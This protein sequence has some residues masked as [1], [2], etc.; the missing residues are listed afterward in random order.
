MRF[1][2]V[3]SVLPTPFRSDASVDLDSLRRVIELYIGAG[4]DGVT[5]LGVT[6]EV[7]R[8]NERE[9][10]E[11]IESVLTEVSGRVPVVA[12]T[13]SQE[14]L[15]CIEYSRKAQLAGATAVM[16]SPPPMSALNSDAVFAHFA[17]L[18]SA[19][20]IE[21]VMQDY[22]PVSGYTMEPALLARITR[23]ISRARTIKL[24]DPPTP[25][26]TTRIL[27]ACRDH[28]VSVLGG[29]GGVYLLE[30]LLAGAAG[31]MTGFAYPE[32]LVE[33]VLLFQAGNFDQAA[34]A[35]YRYV[36]LMRFEFQQGIGIALRKEIL[37]RRG[38]IAESII[39]A[40]GGT[41]D[42][43]TLRALDSLLRWMRDKQGVALISG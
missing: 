17:E 5:A 30:E 37:R 34:D 27:E 39:R 16:V 9:R 20:D 19:V 35:F 31:T 3:Y 26:K 24:E 29:L 13:T 10:D 32:M 4:V 15:I 2:G 38:A 43:C 6:S 8:L 36:P 33:V 40:P 21:I 18:A 42:Q 12:G 23:E 22:P 41:L 7:A 11:V 1:K 28:E 14:S 25:L